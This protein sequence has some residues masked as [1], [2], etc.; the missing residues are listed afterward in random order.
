MLRGVVDA[1][2]AR[3]TPLVFDADGLFF[4]ASA[5]EIVQSYDRALLT[6]NVVEFERLWS[7]VVGSDEAG[8]DDGAD[9]VATLAGKL[10]VTILRKGEVD[11]ISNGI[12][13]TS[14]DIAGSPRRCGG[15][16]DVVSGLAGMFL[17][18]VASAPRRAK[19]LGAAGAGDG[20]ADVAEQVVTAALGASAL[21]RCAAETAFDSRG[22]SMT[23]PDL[24]SALPDAFEK[25]FPGRLHDRS[26]S[27]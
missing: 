7:S 14:C 11:V 12:A 24:M 15:Q 21:T 25:L 10:G 18:W 16:G 2:K 17:S 1:A 23:T 3:N 22:R 26:S 6:P 20:E 19:A 5:P 4:V 8:A 9:R 27:L 13:T